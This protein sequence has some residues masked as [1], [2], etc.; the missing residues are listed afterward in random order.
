[1]QRIRCGVFLYT[2]SVCR[3]TY[4]I[5]VFIGRTAFHLPEPLREVLRIQEVHLV[6]DLT[7]ALARGDDALFGNHQRPLLDVL[8]G[9]QSGFF[10]YQVAEI[11]GGKTEL[12][13]TLLYRRDTCRCRLTRVIIVVKQSLE[14]CQ[15]IAVPILAR[16]ELAVVEA[17]A[18]VEQQLHVVDDERAAVLVNRMGKFITQTADTICENLVGSSG[19]LVV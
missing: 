19:W 10:F 7:E 3:L 9:G 12:V 1:M 18:L 8:D 16:N 2:Q 11:V 14:T 5:A 17:Y 13:G 4:T 6:G 15:K